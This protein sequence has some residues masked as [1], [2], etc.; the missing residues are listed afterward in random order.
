M[1]SALARAAL[2][3]G[4]TRPPADGVADFLARCHGAAVAV[5]AASRSNG[6]AP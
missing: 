2:L 4:L 5:S 6:E 3:A 1:C